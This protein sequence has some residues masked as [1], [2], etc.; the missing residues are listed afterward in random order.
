MHVGIA[1]FNTEY[2]LR[3]DEI[4]RA[5]EERCYE[6]LWLPEHT[7]VPASRWTP[8]PRGG[9][10]SKPYYHESDPVVSLMAAAAANARQS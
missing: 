6:S 7:H 9:E 1:N 5:L 3:P 4:A 10:L 8:F 2:G